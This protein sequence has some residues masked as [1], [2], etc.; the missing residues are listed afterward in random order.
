MPLDERLHIDELKRVERQTTT[1]LK[2]WRRLNRDH[3]LLSEKFAK[4]ESA[5][6]DEQT[7]HAAHL[8]RIQDDHARVQESSERQWKEQ[9]QWL[10]QRHEEQSR[11]TTQAH[12]EQLA[13]LREEHREQIDTMQAQIERLER[14]LNVLVARVRGVHHE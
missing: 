10:E 6:A 11:D 12:Q 9:V 14:Q 4:L 1:L 3:A 2:L 7:N 13:A 5:Y 8:Q